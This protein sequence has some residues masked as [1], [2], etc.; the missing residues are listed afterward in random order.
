MQ[1]PNPHKNA[2]D[3]MCLGYHCD[4]VARIC[5]DVSLTRKNEETRKVD[6]EQVMMQ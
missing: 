1:C 3:E 5:G 6:R 4:A 2:P